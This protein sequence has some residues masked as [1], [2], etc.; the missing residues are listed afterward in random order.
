MGRQSRAKVNESRAQT[1]GHPKL[2]AEAQS[3]VR[4]GTNSCTSPPMSSPLALSG[5]KEALPI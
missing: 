5:C 3:R 2:H 1:T 4:E